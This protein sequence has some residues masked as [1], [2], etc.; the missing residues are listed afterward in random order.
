MEK[1]IKSIRAAKKETI[2]AFDRMLGYYS[3]FL[4]DYRNCV[5]VHHPIRDMYSNFKKM[6]L[7][8]LYE[9]P[10]FSKI[11]LLQITKNV[12]MVDGQ[13]VIKSEQECVIEKIAR[14]DQ[15]LQE[16]VDVLKRKTEEFNGIIQSTSRILL[17]NTKI[18]YAWSPTKKSADIT[19]EEKSV[20]R[21]GTG[22][23]NGL[24]LSDQ[25][26]PLGITKWGIKADVCT[27]WIL[28]GIALE[29]VIK[30]NKFKL[31]GHSNIGHGVYMV[32]C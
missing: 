24:I 1:H 9:C 28:L 29:N 16:V 22:D 30:N 5:A 32:S 11:N 13:L 23:L 10:D 8:T 31:L 20:W 27:K 18:D 21:P 2:Q 3:H 19:I 17:R 25:T 7:E 14:G 12:K 6:I 15:S 26:L 4:K